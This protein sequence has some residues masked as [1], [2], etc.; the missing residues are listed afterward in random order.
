M[1]D[2]RTSEE[3]EEREKRERRERE[4]EK[5]EE[6]MASQLVRRSWYVAA[7][8]SPSFVAHHSRRRRR[9]NGKRNIFG[10]VGHGLRSCDHH[11]PSHRRGLL[12]Q[13]HQQQPLLRG[14]RSY[15]RGNGGQSTHE[16]N[17]LVLEADSRIGVEVVK[18]FLESDTHWNVTATV[19]GKNMRFFCSFQK[20]QNFKI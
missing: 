16:K 10:F 11:Y 19:R 3:R 15:A 17:V 7:G 14:K 1:T 8:T 13:L 9:G 2:A 12:H 5:R 20:F 18:A 4:R 6:T